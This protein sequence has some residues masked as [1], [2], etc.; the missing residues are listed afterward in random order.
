LHLHPRASDWIS[1]L[2]VWSLL[3]D[4]QEA[5]KQFLVIFF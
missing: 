5:D 3:S 4:S 1:L 2:Y